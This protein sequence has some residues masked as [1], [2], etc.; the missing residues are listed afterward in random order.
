[1]QIT[2]QNPTDRKKLILLAVLGFAAIL[3]LWWTFIGFG[4][5]PSKPATPRATAQPTPPSAVSRT[6]P[7]PTAAPQSVAE[8]KGTDLA[9]LVPVSIGYSPVSV[10]AVKRNIFV[11]YEPPPVP[12]VVPSVPTPTPTPT[13]PVLLANLSPPTV[14]AR[15]A[16]FTMEATG[17]KFTPQLRIT[18]D[19][20]ELPTRYI[21]PQQLSTTV[22]AALIANPGSRQVMVRS[23]DGKVYS[24]ALMISISAPPTPNYSYIGILGTTRH[25][26]T[27]ILQDKANKETLS[28][29]RGDLLGGRFR[30][31]SISEKEVVVVDNNLNVKH[32]LAITNQGDKG[33][34]LQ[35][36]TPRVESEDDEP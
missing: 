20:T 30:V 11:Y 3:L 18:I 29:Q 24:N 36:P 32:K 31:T 13:P 2:S 17:D 28:V 27:A 7:N 8:F 6:N 19:N 9:Q 14:F 10:P 25:I 23:V 34:P 22:P 33:N 5:S 26:D 15:T 35:R 12:V 21:S 4:S 16:D 1:M